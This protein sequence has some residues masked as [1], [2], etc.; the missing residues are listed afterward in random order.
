MAK[1][2][3][4]GRCVHCLADPVPRNWDHLFPQSWYP[5]TTPNNQEKWQFPSCIPCNDKYGNMESDFLSRVGLCLDPHHV[6]S[7]SIVAKALRSLKPEAA[8]NERDRKFRTAKGMKILKSAEGIGPLPQDSVVPG[9]GVPSDD[10]NEQHPITI[11]ADHFQMLVSKVVRGVYY[12]ADGLF[13]EPTHKIGHHLLHPSVAEEM[14]APFGAAGQTFMRE[15]CLRIR[16]FVAHDDRMN[17]I[18]E[19][20][21]WQQLKVYA[22]LGRQ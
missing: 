22:F 15:P 5:D 9:L 14:L 8:R 13:I 3:L 12:L 4:P 11:A 10:P 7:K 16:R 19:I 2:P 20:V 6:A 1:A 21:L 18:F 17:S